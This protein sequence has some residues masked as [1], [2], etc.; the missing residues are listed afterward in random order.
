M[1]FESAI[2]R[3]HPYT[4]ESFIDV[5]KSMLPQHM[6][7]CP[8]NFVNHGTGL[9]NS[10]EELCAYISAYGEMHEIKC[11]G[12]FQNI[13]FDKLGNIEIW[14][15]GCGQGLASL[16]LID[17]LRE[18]EKLHLLKKVTLIEP[19]LVALERA[20]L[21]VKTAFPSI[22]I[23]TINKYLPAESD[24]VDQI[25]SSSYISPNV[26]HLFSNVLDINTID[27]VKL[28]QVVASPGKKTLYNVCWST[29][30]RCLQDRSICVYI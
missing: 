8:W 11:R 10:N 14:D 29:E 27:L 3:I 28:A 23:I 9:L 12:A 20:E 1:G 4:M 18:R 15:W 16:T 13:D 25:R 2:S 26:I 30:L 22:Q 5:S 19:S 7:V 6:R 21:N 24:S 17:M